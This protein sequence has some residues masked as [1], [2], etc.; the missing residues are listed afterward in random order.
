MQKLLLLI[1]L[2]PLASYSQEDYKSLLKDVTTNIPQG[3]VTVTS[4]KTRIHSSGSVTI[5]RGFE[6]NTGA[7]L[8]ITTGN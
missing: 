3:Y 2:F 4:G 7:Q 1:M 8:E 6:V 5:P